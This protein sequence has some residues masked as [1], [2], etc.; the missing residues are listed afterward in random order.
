M[1]AGLI[2]AAGN[3][4]KSIDLRKH[5][6]TSQVH[7]FHGNIQIEIGH[8]HFIPILSPDSFIEFVTYHII[9]IYCFVSTTENF[10]F[11]PMDSKEHFACCSQPFESRR[12]RGQ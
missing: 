1:I 8:W 2:L 10:A 9:F 7:S 5:E 11:G 12:Q 3:K 4:L 6:F